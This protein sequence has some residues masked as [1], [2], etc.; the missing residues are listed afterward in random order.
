MTHLVTG[1]LCMQRSKYEDALVCFDK[2]LNLDDD[3]FVWFAKGIA[4]SKMKKYADARA[5]FVLAAN[6]DFT[7]YVNCFMESNNSLKPYSCQIPEP[8]LEYLL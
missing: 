5:H 8:K 4:F 3:S 1:L 2:S 7:E 6:F